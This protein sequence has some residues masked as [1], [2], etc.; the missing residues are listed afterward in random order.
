MI[1]NLNLMET[2]KMKNIDEILAEYALT[3]EEMICV[4]GGDAGEPILKPSTP[5]IKI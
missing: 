1:K 4:K 5:P 2:L 3:V